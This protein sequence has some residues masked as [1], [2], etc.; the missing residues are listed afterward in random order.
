MLTPF[1]LL[2]FQAILGML[3]AFEKQFF[4]KCYYPLGDLNDDMALLNSSINF[5]IYYFMSKQFRKNFLET[6]KLSKACSNASRTVNSFC[7]KHFTRTKINSSLMSIEMKMH[8]ESNSNRRKPEPRP[9][10]NLPD[11]FFEYK[12]DKTVETEARV[13]AVK[14]SPSESDPMLN[15]SVS[16]S[17]QQDKA[18]QADF[19]ER[20][21]KKVTCLEQDIKPLEV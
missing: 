17:G 6:F 7:R 1:S 14:D 15:P 18:S 20:P 3:S 5:L 21:S 16:N 12:N 11:D 2:S 19:P 8:Q 10:T 4:N 9:P 13:D